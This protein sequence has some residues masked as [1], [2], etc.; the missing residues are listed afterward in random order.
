MTGKNKKKILLSRL[1]ILGVILLL[2]V[3]VIYFIQPALFFYPYHDAQAYEAL[4]ETENFQEI[5]IPHQKGYLHGWL[6][7]DPQTGSAPLVILYGGNSQNSSA[8]FR[9]FENT[10]TF[11]WFRGYDV[12]FVDY[13]GYG[14]SDG[15]PGEKTLFSAGLAVFDYSK[16]IEDTNGKVIL[17]GYS[18]GTGVATYVASQ[19]T[20]DGLILL[21]PYDKGLS[22]YND[23]CNIFHGPLTLLA[24]FKFDSV[25]YAQEV[26]VPTILLASR[27][28][29]VI[30][31]AHAIELSRHFPDLKEILIL[32]GINHEGFFYSSQVLEQ[33]QEYLNSA[34]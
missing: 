15:K 14:L 11:R 31:Y 10:D 5:S 18:I 27:D 19:R 34:I 6:H 8:W 21:A 25:T 16:T 4:R 22:L 17:L 33:I 30:P 1:S 9:M 26:T 28:D 29:E 7:R 23:A 12:L 3:G 24:R 13:P 2:M 20:I 32:E